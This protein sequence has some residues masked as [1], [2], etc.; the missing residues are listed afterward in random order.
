MTYLAPAFDGR[1][2]IWDA[3]RGACYALEQNDNDL[4]QS[5]KIP[6]LINS[7]FHPLIFQ[8]SI[9]LISPFH[10]VLYSIVMMNLVH[11][12]N[13][14]SMFS[15]HQRISSMV[16]NH[17]LILMVIMNPVVVRSISLFLPSLI[18]NVIWVEII[19]HRHHHRR[20]LLRISL[21]R[22]QQQVNITVDTIRSFGK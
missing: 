17:R 22:Q 18:V 13:Y 5:S 3:L 16:N 4:A 6:S 14:Q 7:F 8:L 2:E 15:R 1:K 10:T 12:I 20:H 19:V 9:V 21:V 11:V